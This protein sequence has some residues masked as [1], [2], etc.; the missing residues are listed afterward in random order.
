MSKRLFKQLNNL[1]QY[2]NPVLAIIADN[3]WRD[4]YYSKSNYIHT[5]YLGILT[6]ILCKYPKLR[7]VQ[8][9]D[10]SQFV[11]FLTSLDKKLCSDDASERPVP[12]MRKA[13]KI[14]EI[15][16]NC[17]A[18]IPGIGISMS[19]KLLH[20]FG[21]IQ[22]ISKATEKEL[23][24]IDKLGKITAGKIIDTLSNKYHVNGKKK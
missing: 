19:K 14:G 11:D 7:I 18:Q 12:K 6:T 13:K 8:L 24:S 17:L 2:E 5:V 21:S 23:Q 3:I 10:D 9:E 4:F 16:E 1:C 15:Q 22:G 20:R